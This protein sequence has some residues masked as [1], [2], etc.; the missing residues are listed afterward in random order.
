M[1]KTF[2]LSESL[3]DMLN[4]LS[5]SKPVAFLKAPANSFPYTL[6]ALKRHFIQNK[7]SSLSFHVVVIVGRVFYSPT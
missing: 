4:Q 2:L 1:E 3:N 7:S 5:G 6:G